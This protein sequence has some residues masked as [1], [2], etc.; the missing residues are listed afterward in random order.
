MSDQNDLVATP[1]P[2]PT[3]TPTVTVVVPT[4]REAQNLPLLLE[5]LAGVRREHGLELDLLIMD[6]RSGD[7]SVEA[8]AAAG[9]PWATLIERT[10]RRGLSPAVLEGIERA[11]GEVVVVMDADLSHPPE[12]IPDMLRALAGGRE[13]VMGSRYVP[14][15]TTDAGWGVYRWLNSRIATWL[16]RPLTAVRDPMSGF[17]AMR[18]ADL[19]RA[20]FLNPV[21][22]KIALEL[23]VKCR[24]KDVGE[25]P[26]HFADRQLGE[27]KLNFKEQLKYLQHLRRLYLFRYGTWSHLAQF[28][29]VGVTGLA[30]N[31]AALTLALWAGAS[32]PV[33]V[34]AGIGVS[35]CTNFWLNRR[36]TFSYAKHGP[37]LRQFAGFVAASAG[38][39]ALNYVVTLQVNAAR[40][41]WPLQVAA[42]IGVAA[43]T[44]VNFLV[45]RYLV[46]PTHK[47]KAGEA[48]AT[49]P[50]G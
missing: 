50:L 33:A 1:T 21:G 39:A 15:G 34:A 40:P 9:H 8:V 16:A 47:R 5:R 4:Y 44:L 41:T 13:F 10:G 46:F 18:R 30:V 29:V 14:G 26:I 49:D 23:I 32:D 43:G 36:F 35:V 31:L 6:D 45:N 2:A 48:L 42:V 19:K 12:R 20:A 22:Y 3:P 7:G 37:V 17:F 24:L 28:L 25:V 27:S 38:G 11:R